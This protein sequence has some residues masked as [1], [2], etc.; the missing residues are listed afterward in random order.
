M[1]AECQV[2]WT[3]WVDTNCDWADNPITGTHTSYIHPCL[4]IG[5]GFVF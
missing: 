1:V 5:K 3:E 4:A 2:E